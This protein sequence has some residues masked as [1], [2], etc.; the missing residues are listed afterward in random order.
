MVAEDLEWVE[1]FDRE[2]FNCR[3]AW[4][5]SDFIG[6]MADTASKA[7][8]ADNLVVSGGGD[9]AGQ[10]DGPI[11]YLATKVVPHYQEH[12]DAEQTSVHVSLECLVCRLAVAP[13]LRRMGIGSLMVRWLK[14]DIVA[15]GPKV[16]RIVAEVDEDNLPAQL[17]FRAC[18]FVATAV[19][20]DGEGEDA[21][22]D[23]RCG[24]DA[25]EMIWRTDWK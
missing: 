13:T 18:G 22:D 19:L 5:S 8:V 23:G 15:N 9:D 7:V 6:A 25:Y 24:P 2:C 12:D 4:S 20:S 10:V 14:D 3:D 21:T 17:F 1:S 16:H 11:G